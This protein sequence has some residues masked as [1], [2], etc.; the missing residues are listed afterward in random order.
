MAVVITYPNTNTLYDNAYN[1]SDDKYSS[2]YGESGA[3]YVYY[4]TTTITTI[5]IQI[6]TNIHPITANLS[7]IIFTITTTTITTILIQIMTDI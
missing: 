6:L 2:N 3:D 5:L 1:S 7:I 4:T